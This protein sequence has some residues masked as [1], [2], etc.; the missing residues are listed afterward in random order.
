MFVVSDIRME[1]IQGPPPSNTAADPTGVNSDA[2]AASG[3]AVT[4]P[5]ATSGTAAVAD[6]AAGAD[7]GST[8]SA[9]NGGGG[10]GGAVDVGTVAPGSG[11]GIASTEGNAGFG[12]GDALKGTGGKYPRL[13]FGPKPNSRRCGV[14]STKTAVKISVGHPLSDKVCVRGGG[15][16]GGLMLA[17]ALCS[18]LI[19][20]GV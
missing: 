3:A 1:P 5:A 19:V 20:C 8:A 12:G 17:S 4:E 14:C 2:D 9:S 15:V 6:A 7:A 18:V 11:G 13:T 10:G 16:S